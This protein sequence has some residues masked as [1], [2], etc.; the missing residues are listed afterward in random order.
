MSQNRYSSEFENQALV[1]V[2][3]RAD[4]SVGTIAQELGLP[5]E[6]LARFRRALGISPDY[7]NAHR[8]LA[9]VQYEQAVQA[10]FRDVADALSARRWLAKQV[11]VQGDAPLAQAFAARITAAAVPSGASGSMVIAR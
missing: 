1:K 8:N 4:K 7:A 11:Q 3:E 5:V 6:A 9:V 10:A 2:R